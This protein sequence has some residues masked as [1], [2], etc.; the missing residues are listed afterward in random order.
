[1]SLSELARAA[2]REDRTPR[3]ETFVEPK[4]HAPSPRPQAPKTSA[5]AKGHIGQVSDNGGGSARRD[6]IL[7]ILG[8][9]GPSYIKDISTLVRDVSEK[10]IQRELGAL[11]QEG[12][13]TRTGE[14]RWTTYAIAA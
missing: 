3:T 10:T 12:K 6:A 2:E 8:S 5:E 9:K 7:S 14:R 13:V 1:M 4:T 11:V